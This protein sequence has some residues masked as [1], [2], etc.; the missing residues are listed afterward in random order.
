MT[1]HFT[2]STT[3]GLTNCMVGE[4]IKPRYMAT[5][6]EEQT[7]REET[8]AKLTNF[9]KHFVCSMIAHTIGIRLLYPGMISLIQKNLLS[10]LNEGRINLLTTFS[11]KRLNQ[12]HIKHLYIIANY[13]DAVFVDRRN[14]SSFSNG[15][16][17]VVTCEGNAGFYEIGCP[18]PPLAAGYSVLG[19]NHPGFGGSS[20]LPWPKHEFESI[21]VVLQFALSQGMTLG[22]CCNLKHSFSGFLEEQIV[23]YAWSIGGFVASWAGVNYPNIKAIILDAPFDDLLPL[24]LKTLPESCSDLVEYTVRNFMNLHTAALIKDYN[25]RLGIIRRSKDEILSSPDDLLGANRC[26]SLINT[27]LSTSDDG[28]SVR[29]DKMEVSQCREMLASYVQK[30]G[31]QFP[32]YVGK[33]EDTAVRRRLSFYLLQHMVTTFDA[34]HCTELPAFLFRVPHHPWEQE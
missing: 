14:G 15:N 9:A 16:V 7:G 22:G 4:K 20:G 28:W 18:K 3:Y 1:S 29:I 24:A 30:H 11:A 31:T 2:Q 26:N 17:L 19:W 10:T 33:E 12:C 21:D 25:G 27:V 34:L 6:V 32:M 13:V 8:G 23:I 5:G